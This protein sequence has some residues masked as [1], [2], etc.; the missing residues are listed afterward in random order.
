MKFLIAGLLAVGQV[1]AMQVSDSKEHP[2]A[3]IINML[4]EQKVKATEN[5][6][7]EAVMY[8]K[9]QYFVKNTLKEL[10]TAI[11]K[12]KEDIEI[13]EAQVESKEKLIEQ[14][15]EDIKDLEEQLEKN[16]KATKEAKK[17][18][19]E[20]NK[21]FE[22]A[23]K[24][25]DSTIDAVQQCID[26]LNDAKGGAASALLAQESVKKVL[27][28]AEAL[29]SDKDRAVLTSFLQ[30]PKKPDAKVYTFKSGSVIE[31]LKKL[32][33]KF[34]T[35]KQDAI[36]AETASL[37]AFNLAQQ[38][39]DEEKE[40]AEKSKEEKEDM[41]GEAE[42]D[43]EE[44]KADLDSTKED[45]KA[46]EES[47]EGLTSE[48]DVKADEWE[49]RT[50]TREGE[51][52]AMDMAIKIMSKV[53]GARPTP[54]LVQQKIPPSFIQIEDPKSQAVKILT[55]EAQ[56]L[57][58]THSKSL[59]RLV[60]Q[61]SSHLT[62][63]FDDINQMIQKM[64]FHLQ[65]EQIDEDD[66]KNWCDTELEKSEDS[67]EDKEDKISELED[68]LEEADARTMKLATEIEEHNTEISDLTAHIKEET[69]IREADKAENQAAIKDAKACQEAITK[70]IGVL[71]DF[72][73][74]AGGFLQTNDRAPVKVPDSPETWDSSYTG[75]DKQPDGIVSMMEKIQ[76]D[77]AKMEADTK[78]EEDSDE[79]AYQA[80]MTETTTNKEAEE[81]SA[82]MKTNE[83]G[84]LIS[85]VKSWKGKKTGVEKELAAVEQYLKDLKPACEDGDST[86]EDRK[87]A[88][89]DEIEAL[90]K[91]QKVLED[92]FKDKLLF[93]Q[94]K[95]NA[96]LQ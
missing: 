58:G 29:V 13:L 20:E 44:F 92:A 34:E 16:E 50:K 63:P 30:G 15:E 77:Y 36:K 1:L 10:E 82:E 87:K 79:T 80:D 49:V 73:K 89:D 66:H 83:R 47:L 93:L 38:A 61:I 32:K 22:E 31:L 45:L 18:R 56:K 37:N 39:R 48:R 24:D 46:N 21:E 19:K 11:K 74:E 33:E 68:K 60:N 14:L 95:V 70:A 43:L 90:K 69:E 54:E 4:E 57:K 8:Q 88:R 7:K 40:A 35:D 67:K 78:A 51:L 71:E 27:G 2:I 53:A 23:D 76:E 17:M 84:L 6:E 65:N 5:G 91:A 52:K 42:T 12:E 26:A 3:K 72:Y 64:I 25:F 96:H 28:L 85:K 59:L 81:K 94:R 9:Y 86:Y 75:L 55:A 62:G 41:K